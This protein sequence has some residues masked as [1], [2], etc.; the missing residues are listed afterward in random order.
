MSVSGGSVSNVGVNYVGV[1]GERMDGV[2]ADGERVDGVRADD[3]EVDGMRDDGV[4]AGVNGV[5]G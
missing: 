3:V 1:D 4:Y 5:T 2:G